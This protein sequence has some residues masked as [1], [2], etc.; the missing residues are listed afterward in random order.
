MMNDQQKAREV[1]LAC[2]GRVA[3]LMQALNARI[4]E[5][6]FTGCAHSLNRSPLAMQSLLSVTL[7]SSYGKF[8]KRLAW[9][10]FGTRRVL[11]LP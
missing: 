10:T 2:R 11:W 9:L 5:Y 8:G 3:L 6:R 4:Y 1:W 7:T